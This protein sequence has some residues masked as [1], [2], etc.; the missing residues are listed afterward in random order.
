M[1][2]LRNKED[3]DLEEFLQIKREC[4]DDEVNVDEANEEDGARESD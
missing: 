1:E 2:D 3:V 4:L